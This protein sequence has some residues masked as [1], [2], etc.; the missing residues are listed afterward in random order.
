VAFNCVGWSAYHLGAREMAS[1][2]DEA[3]HCRRDLGEPQPLRETS[4]PRGRIPWQAHSG[5][6][7]V[8]TP[9]KVRYDV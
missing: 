9:E 1:C 2:I 6:E 5:A 7:C 3:V 4:R 8:Q